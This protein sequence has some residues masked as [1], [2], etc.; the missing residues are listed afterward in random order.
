VSSAAQPGKGTCGSRDIIV[1]ANCHAIN[2]GAI[3]AF[4][5]G[6]SDLATGLLTGKLWFRVR[7]C[8]ERPCTGCSPLSIAVLPASRT[9]A[10]VSSPARSARAR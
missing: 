1:G 6:S 5:V 3:N 2:E 8:R 4:G 7:G 9:C 10:G